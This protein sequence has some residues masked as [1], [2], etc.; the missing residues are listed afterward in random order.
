MIRAKKDLKE[1][2]YLYRKY[3]PKIN[4]FVFHR[5]NN[6]SDRHEI[7]S[8]VFFKAMKKISLFHYLDSCKCSFSSWLYRITVNE[9]NQFYRDQKRSRKIIDTYVFNQVDGTEMGFSYQLVRNKLRNFESVIKPFFTIKNN[10]SVIGLSLFK[11]VMSVH[12]GIKQHIQRKCSGRF[13]FKIL[14]LFILLYS[15]NGITQH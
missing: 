12:G 13:H 11:Q 3:F 8:N 15:A 9:I 10:N 2:D 14:N 1:F 4:N 5:V 7:V 6:E